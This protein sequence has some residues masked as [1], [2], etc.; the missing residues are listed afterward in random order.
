VNAL[1]CDVRYIDYLNLLRGGSGDDAWS[2]LSDMA[3]SAKI[4]AEQTNS[5]NVLLVQVNEEGKIRYSRGV[6]EHSSASWVW[7]T[8]PEERAKEVGRIV[9]EQPKSR[10]SSAF[11]MELG[12]HWK[13]MRLAKLEDAAEVGELDTPKNLA[14]DV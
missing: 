5:V 2:K 13:C 8:K 11:P 9:V 10:N 4:N 1:G 6:S 12:L 7:N 14:A 3:R